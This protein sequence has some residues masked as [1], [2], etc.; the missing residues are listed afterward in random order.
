MGD[1]I[2]KHTL[3][4]TACVR[5]LLHLEASW[6][7]GDKENHANAKEDKNPHAEMEQKQ[8]SCVSQAQYSTD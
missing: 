6:Q 2:L 7:R 3:S 8:K 5:A 4:S 1:Q